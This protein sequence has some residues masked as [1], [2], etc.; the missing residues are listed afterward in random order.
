MF[1]NAYITAF[2]FSKK[3]KKGVSAGLVAQAVTAG[4]SCSRADICVKVSNC[5]FMGCLVCFSQ[6]VLLFWTTLSHVSRLQ[7]RA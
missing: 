5:F 1:F 6:V 4:W 2:L 7:E 3:K